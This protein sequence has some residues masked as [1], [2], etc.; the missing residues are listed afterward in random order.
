MLSTPLDIGTQIA[1][2]NGVVVFSWFIAATVDLGT[3]TLTVTGTQS[4]SVSRD[5]AVIA[6]RLSATGAPSML[7]P[8]AGVAAVF[9][10]SGLLVWLAAGP[11][12]RRRPRSRTASGQMSD[13]PPTQPPAA[14]DG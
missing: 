11:P 6:G 2:P 1:D 5:F 13:T 14:A 10:G 9:V 4:G 12:R 7:R 3:H 8:T